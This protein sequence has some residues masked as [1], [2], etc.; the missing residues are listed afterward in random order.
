MPAPDLRSLTHHGNCK[1]CRLRESNIEQYVEIHDWFSQGWTCQRVCEE[2]KERGFRI[3]VAVVYRHRRLHWQAALEN[4]LRIETLAKKGI[5]ID[6]QNRARHIVLGSIGELLE[7]AIRALRQVKLEDLSHG[8]HDKLLEV[9]MEGCRVVQSEETID[10]AATEMLR[11]ELRRYPKIRMALGA[12]LAEMEGKGRPGRPRKNHGRQTD[13]AEDDN[14]G[15][16]DGGG[17]ELSAAGA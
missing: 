11:A 2:L 6:E 17:Q 1:I 14:T 12:A 13:K 16:D 9:I 10:K 3:G 15:R 8:K 5:Y 7:M 4:E